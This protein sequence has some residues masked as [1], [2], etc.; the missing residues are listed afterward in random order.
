[1]LLTSIGLNINEEARLAGVEVVMSKPVRQSQLYDALA[2]MMGSPADAPASPAPGSARPDGTPEE[3]AG[4]ILLAEDYPINRMVAVAL[5]E[6][7]GYKVDAVG[8][9]KE[10]VEALSGVPYAA[11]LMDV[12]MPEMD[13]YEA[14]A[15]IRRREEPGRRT[16]IIAMTANAMQ[17]D[18]EKALEAGMDDYIAKPVRR[19]DL[20]AVLG[21]WIPRPRQDPPAVD[22]SVL[23]SRRDPQKEGEP[24]KLARIVTLFIDDVPPRIEALRRAVERGRPGR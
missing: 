15:E 12:Q 22:L 5:L 16:P 24:D 1:V 17:G 7:S 4:H 19:E 23:E 2:R 8:N 11:V 6:R 10:A 14:T 18:R 13:G 20:E 9:G 21:H 3:N